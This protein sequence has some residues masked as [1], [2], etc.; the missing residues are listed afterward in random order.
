MHSGEGKMPRERQSS[1]TPNKQQCGKGKGW[2]RLVLLGG[3][4]GSQTPHHYTLL[5]A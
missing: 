4:Q 1:P 5:E 2:G 3:F